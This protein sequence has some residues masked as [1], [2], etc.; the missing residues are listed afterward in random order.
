MIRYKVGD[1]VA[2]EIEVRLSGYKYVLSRYIKDESELE[3]REFQI[4]RVHYVFEGA[5]PTYTILISD[6]LVGWMISQFHVENFLIASA[7]KN[8]KFW[9]LTEEFIIKKVK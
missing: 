7:H 1:V 5:A 6:D 2:C 4:I 3:I 9:E 8:K